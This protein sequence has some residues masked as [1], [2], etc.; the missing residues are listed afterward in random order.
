[1]KNIS[2]IVVL[3]AGIFSFSAHADQKTLIS[4]PTADTA[5]DGGYHLTFITSSSDPSKL[6]MELLPGGMVLN[7]KPI[8]S[9][10]VAVTFLH[11]LCKGAVV[12]RTPARD[13]YFQLEF[14]DSAT[15]GSK[16]QSAELGAKVTVFRY[17]AS[18]YLTQQMKTIQTCYVG[19]QMLEKLY[20]VQERCLSK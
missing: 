9:K 1:M 20:E 18:S 6:V 13:I 4:C 19:E 10:N 11:G 8:I 12:H 16:R 15:G 17:K 7:R 2:R 14:K 5:A 3:A